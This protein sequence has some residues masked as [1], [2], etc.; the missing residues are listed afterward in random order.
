MRENKKTRRMSPVLFYLLLVSC[1]LLVIC[2]TAC[3]RRGDPI[4]IEPYTEKVADRDLNEIKKNSGNSGNILPNEH[5]TDREEV[6]ATAPDSPTGLVGIYTEKSI[7]LTWDEMTGHNIKFYRIYR[8]AD[9]DY[10]VVGDTVTP[11]FTDRNVDK[12]VKY[13]YKITAV[14]ALESLPSNKIGIKTEIR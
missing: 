2:S 12:N 4:L 8:S 14:G 10:I 5:D 6:K 7:V 3:G 1:F 13:Y 11:A 9:D